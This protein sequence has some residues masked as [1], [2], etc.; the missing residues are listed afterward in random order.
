MRV[1]SFSGSMLRQGWECSG[2]D[3]TV[4]RYA[5]SAVAA[6]SSCTVRKNSGTPAGSARSVA[7]RSSSGSGSPV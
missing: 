6:T 5:V 1:A 7:S 3:M 2:V 4:P